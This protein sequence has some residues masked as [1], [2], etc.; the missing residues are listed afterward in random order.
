MILIF[1]NN[2]TVVCAT[3]KSGE[4]K[5]QKYCTAN[6]GRNVKCTPG[7]QYFISFSNSNRAK[8]NHLIDIIYSKY[9]NT[10]SCMAILMSLCILCR[11]DSLSLFLSGWMDGWMEI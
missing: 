11:K 10:E 7:L 9:L 3:D 1:K 4:S 6:E 8:K 5:K 2:N